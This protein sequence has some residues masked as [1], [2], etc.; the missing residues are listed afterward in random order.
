MRA[1]RDQLIIRPHTRGARVVGDGLLLADTISSRVPP[2]QGT[3]LHAGARAQVIKEGDRVVWG[4]GV[5][6][7]FEFEDGPVVVLREGDV[8]CRLMSE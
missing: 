2:T 8:I 5:G 6:D 1:L 7:R 3:V 4:L